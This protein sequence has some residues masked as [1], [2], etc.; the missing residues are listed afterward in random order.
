METIVEDHPPPGGS[1]DQDYHGQDTTRGVEEGG[2]VVPDKTSTSTLLECGAA[3]AKKPGLATTD[4]P[5]LSQHNLLTDDCP[6]D[7]M[8][9]G[10][11]RNT[12]PEMPGTP[13]TAILRDKCAGR[14]VDDGEA[15]LMMIRA[16]LGVFTTST[17][18]P[19]M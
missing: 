18:A 13:S 14:I 16:N 6:F 2:T 4:Q 11:E 15:G 7:E 5:R 17:P 12:I 19:S 10:V 3:L 9:G 1:I 8:G